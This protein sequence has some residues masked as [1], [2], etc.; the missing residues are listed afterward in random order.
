MDLHDLEREILRDP[1]LLRLSTLAKREKIPVFLVGG[2]LRDLLLGIKRKDYDFTLPREASFFIPAIESAF[3]F[4]FFKVGKGIETS[5]FRIVTEEISMDIT[6]FQGRDIAEDLF[7]RDFTINT[8]A[9]SLRD[10][11]WQWAEGAMEDIRNRR[12]RAVSGRSL[13]RDPL[14]MLRAVRYACT[15]D[16][17]SID[18]MLKEEIS[19]KK[20][21]ILRI[22]AERVKA[23]LDQILLSSRPYVG[24][25]LLYETGLLFTLLPELAG[26]ENLGQNEHHHLNVL[27]H[28]LLAIQRVPWAIERARMSERAIFLSQEDLLCLYYAILFHDIGKQDTYSKDERERVH[29]YHHETFSC[30][31]SEGI[32]KRLRFSTLLKEKVLYLV[33]NHMTIL[34]LPSGTKETTLKRLVHEMGEATPLLVIHSFADKDASRGILSNRTRRS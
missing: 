28:T 21:L 4:R 24:M 26:L 13:D 34:K 14:R 2:Y 22:P 16:N 27:S 5:T 30:Q 3:G 7:R 15:L 9:F 32:M 6:F 25:R 20:D 17:F 31:A 8:L 1:I 12:I 10:E 18:E 11:T 23:E 19:S 29:F 33:G